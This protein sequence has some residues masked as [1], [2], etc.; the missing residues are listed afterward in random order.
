MR[1]YIS[2]IRFASSLY[3]VTHV[4]GA[5][6]FVT[7]TT[8]FGVLTTLPVGVLTELRPYAAVPPGRAAGRLSLT[9]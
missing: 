5:F 9:L 8:R 1:T 6:C 3:T 4:L 7:W 2:Y